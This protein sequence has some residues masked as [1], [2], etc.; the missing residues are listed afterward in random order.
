MAETYQVSLLYCFEL[1]GVLSDFEDKNSVIPQ[2][3]LDEYTV[4]K[5]KGSISKGM[6]PKM[7]N[8]FDAIQNGVKQV[9]ICHSEDMLDVAQGIKKGTVLKK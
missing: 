5:T 9:V 7:D 8:S 1:K 2:I 3:T 6:I 4:L